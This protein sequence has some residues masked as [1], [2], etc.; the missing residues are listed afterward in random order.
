VNVVV[1]GA[2]GFVGGAL[3]E[4]LARDPGFSLTAVVRLTQSTFPA[5][6]RVLAVSDIDRSLDCGG[7]LLSC[8][9][10]VHLAARVHVMRERS[11]DPLAAFRRVN[12]EGTLNLARQAAAAGVRRFIYLSSIK[13]NGESTPLDRPFTADQAANPLDAYGLSKWEAEVG[14]REI[15]AATGMEVVVIRPP[16]VYGSRVRGNFL[17]MMKWLHKGAIL[18]FGA[19]EQNRRSFVSVRNLVDL[20]ITCITHPR[21]CGQIFLVSDGEDLSTAELLKRLGCALGRPARLIAV[22]VPLLAAG[23]RLVGRSDLAGRL[24]GSLRVDISKARD[25]IGWLPP[26]TVDSELAETARGY[27]SDSPS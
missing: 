14:L 24:L 17:A 4:Q 1:T 10:V 20:I 8:D 26:F 12:V 27:L 9:V 18:P 15:S 5:G 19:V 6:V 21:A 2:A 16:L 11:G 22:P 23:A 3:L 7:M 13:V 25:L